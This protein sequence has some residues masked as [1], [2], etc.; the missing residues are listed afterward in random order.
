MIQKLPSKKC[1]FNKEHFELLPIFYQHKDSLKSPIKCLKVN[2][3]Y[4]INR[5]VLKDRFNIH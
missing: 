2:I 1:M 3:E 5:V 4:C